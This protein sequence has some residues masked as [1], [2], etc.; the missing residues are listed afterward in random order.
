MALKITDQFWQTLSLGIIAGMR[1]MAAPA[2]TSHILS[3]HHSKALEGS[4]LN[5]M[6]SEKVALV[7]KVLAVS[8]FVGDKMPSAPNRIKPTALGARFLSGALAGASIYKAAGG[9]AITGALLG[10]ATAA[11][12]TF[13]SFYIRKA[14]VKKTGILDP[15]IGFIEDALVAGGGAK[16]I[17]T[18]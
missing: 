4:P 6:Q 12:S 5:L 15:V 16:L 1:S 17:T 7:L 18:A 13:A 9:N 3:H 11:A 14:T 10:G 8:E 2:I